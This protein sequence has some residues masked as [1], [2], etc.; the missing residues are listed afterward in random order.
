LRFFVNEDF[1]FLSLLGDRT[2]SR[3]R[4]IAA[5]ALGASC[6]LPGARVADDE[7]AATLQDWLDEFLAGPVL[8]WWE[9]LA[10]TVQSWRP[11]QYTRTTEQPNRALV[12]LAQHDKRIVAAIGRK[13]QRAYTINAND[14]LVTVDDYR[15]LIVAWR[16]GAP[17]RLTEVARVV[18]APENN[19]LGAWANEMPAIILN[20]QRQPGANVIATVDSIK[21][22]L[23]ELKASLPASLTVEVL[24][25]RTTGI[26]ASL[27]HVQMELALAVLMVV[28]V[29]F[30]FLHSLRAT[31]IASLAVPI[32]LIGTC[33]VMYLLGYSLNNLSLMA[34]TIAT[35]F[36]VDDAIVMIENIAR[37]LEKGEPPFRAALQGATQIGFT[38]ISMTLSPFNFM[39]TAPFT[40]RFSLAAGVSGNI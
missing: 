38:I 5:R 36:V 17:V 4:A 29:I 30:F 14:Q 27:R 31:V 20:V 34:L 23:P 7:L 37:H 2:L 11:T 13:P 9:Y 18:D 3:Y 33:G 39:I 22:Q 15:N 24:S 16:N 19:R 21:K 1:E 8:P 32:S 35:G 26:R 40:R 10:D 12:M 25:D 28:L 6:P